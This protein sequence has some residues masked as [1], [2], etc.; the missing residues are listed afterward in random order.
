MINLSLKDTLLSFP[1]E[2]YSNL[3][4]LKIKLID[5]IF[6]SQKKKKGVLHL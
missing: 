3:Q 4:P 5:Y 2:I 1:Y 6:L